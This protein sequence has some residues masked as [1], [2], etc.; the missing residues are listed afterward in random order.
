VRSN[1]HDTSKLGCGS[2]KD[3]SQEGR[4]YNYTVK[5]HLLLKDETEEYVD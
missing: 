2:S 3:S 5:N 1:V 4:L